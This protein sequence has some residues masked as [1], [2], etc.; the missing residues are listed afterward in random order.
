M[1]YDKRGCFYFAEVPVEEV[2]EPVRWTAMKMLDHVE[3]DL[4]L[5]LL[6]IRWFRCMHGLAPKE[7]IRGD[8]LLLG[9]LQNNAP[10][11]VQGRHMA[12]APHLIWV[13]ATLSPYAASLVVAH[14]ARHAFQQLRWGRP[15][16][17]GYQKLQAWMREMDRDAMHYE[18]KLSRLAYEL[19]EKHKRRKGK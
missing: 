4:K 16:A 3:R 15:P 19:E 13:R 10:R 9:L 5:P 17:G 6:A 11:S 14:E 8:S 12:I 2:R 1:G 7:I 18:A